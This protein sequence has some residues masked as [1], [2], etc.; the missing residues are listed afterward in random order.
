MRYFRFR[1]FHPAGPSGFENTHD[2]YLW[3]HYYL[4]ISSFF[5]SLSIV[6]S[7]YALMF[8]SIERFLVIRFP[9]QFR[10]L[11][12][13]LFRTLSQA[14][15]YESLVYIRHD[16]VS[17]F[18]RR[19]SVYAIVL[20]WI[21]S[22]SLASLPFFFRSSEKSQIEIADTECSHFSLFFCQPHMRKLCID[23]TLVTSVYIAVSQGTLIVYTT[24]A[25]IPLAVVWIVNIGLYCRNRGFTVLS[26]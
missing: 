23:V 6:S 3:V 9:L 18:S 10:S 7:V 24:A 12:K 4:E 2:D 14:I 20:T 1:N 21:I 17:R 25:L 16:K 8:H 15:G 22:A 19:P 13:C 5:N 11:G 26:I